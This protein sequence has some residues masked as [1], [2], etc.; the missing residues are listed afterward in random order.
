MFLFLPATNYR[1]LI[2]NLNLYKFLLYE[3]FIR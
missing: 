1:R 2:K 3:K